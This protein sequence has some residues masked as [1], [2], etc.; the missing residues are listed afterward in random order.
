MKSRDGSTAM[1]SIARRPNKICM[2]AVLLLGRNRKLGINEG[3]SCVPSPITRTSVL[4][5][6]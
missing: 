1:L 3:V 5:S 6:L 4:Y 2:T